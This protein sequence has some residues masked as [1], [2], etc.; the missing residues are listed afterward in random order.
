[1]IIIIIYS[2]CC[3]FLKFQILYAIEG[4]NRKPDENPTD[5]TGMERTDMINYKGHDFLPLTFRTPTS[6]DSCHKPVWHVLH[7]PP[8]MEC[9]REKI[10]T[11]SLKILGMMT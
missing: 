7:P 11:L 1:M 8:A 4:E 6:C 3:C 5:S 10:F 9:K 2:F